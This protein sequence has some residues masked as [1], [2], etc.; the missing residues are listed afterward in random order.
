MLFQQEALVA[1]KIIS[2][3]EHATIYELYRY[4]VVKFNNLKGPL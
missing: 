1:V 3:N 4:H 2:F